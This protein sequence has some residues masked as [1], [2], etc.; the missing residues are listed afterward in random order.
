MKKTT[1]LKWFS[2]PSDDLSFKSWNS[3]AN[4]APFSAANSATWCRNRFPDTQNTGTLD[5]PEFN[6]TQTYPPPP[7]FWRTNTTFPSLY[8][9]LILSSPDTREGALALFSIVWVQQNSFLYQ[10]RSAL[11]RLLCCDCTENVEVST[12]STKCKTSLD[13]NLFLK[14][15]QW[16]KKTLCWRR[17]YLMSTFHQTMLLFPC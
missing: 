7:K 14:A 9:S 5:T 1:V 16:L 4:P 6:R 2:L 8:L 10:A 15:P 17:E 12:I 13:E 11:P 3:R